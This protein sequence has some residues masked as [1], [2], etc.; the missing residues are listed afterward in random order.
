MAS[1]KVEMSLNKETIEK[2]KENIVFTTNRTQD[3]S[4]W[5]VKQSHRKSKK[6]KKKKKRNTMIIIKFT[7]NLIIFR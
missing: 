3:I 4:Q 5:K 7:K 1:N 2:I 6:E